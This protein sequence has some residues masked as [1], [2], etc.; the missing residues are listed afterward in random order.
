M[1]DGPIFAQTIETDAEFLK[2][3]TKIIEKNLQYRDK[4]PLSYC[5]ILDKYASAYF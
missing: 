2:I 1:D 5:H 4:S 3:N